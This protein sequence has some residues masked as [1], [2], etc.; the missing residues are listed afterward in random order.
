MLLYG[1]P[2]SSARTTV[3]KTAPELQQKR[4]AR[5]MT[6]LT[7]GLPTLPSYVF[8][9]NTLLSSPSVDLKRVA[10]VIRNDASMSAQVIR[11]CNSALFTLRRPVLIIQDAH[12]L[13]GSVL[14]LT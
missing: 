8:E 3:E 14:L 10:K 1:Q 5:L 11:L 12:I 4:K 2:Q 7:E 13:I 6:F 9:L